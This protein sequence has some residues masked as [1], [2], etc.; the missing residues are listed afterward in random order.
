MKFAKLYTAHVKFMSLLVDQAVKNQDASYY[1]L[2]HIWLDGLVNRNKPEMFECYL[3]YLTNGSSIK[4]KELLSDYTD[5]EERNL[6][7]FNTYVFIDSTH[8]KLNVK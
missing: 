4:L 5:F 7:H 3:D 6:F 1:H 2:A 8:F